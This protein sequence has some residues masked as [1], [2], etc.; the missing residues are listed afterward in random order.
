M[1]PEVYKRV[2][3]VLSA[4]TILLGLGMIGATFTSIGPSVRIGVA[5]GGLLVVLGAMRLYWT[6]RR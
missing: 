4:V 1:R 6:L 2:R 5:F 3:L